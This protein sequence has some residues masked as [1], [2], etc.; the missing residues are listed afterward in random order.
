MKNQ[1]HS[2]KAIASLVL[3]AGLTFVNAAH[4]QTV[5][6]FNSDPFAGSTALVTPGRQV[7][8]GAPPAGKELFLPSFDTLTDLFAFDL[9]VPAFNSV[10]PL[11]FFKGFA[12][13]IPSTGFNVI[14]LQSID[15]DNNP[16]TGFNAG[17][18]ANLIAAELDDVVTPGFFVYRNSG[19]S[20]N[21]LVYSTDLSVNTA[22]LAVL[23]RITSPTGNFATAELAKFEAAN[24]ASV[25][26]PSTM[27]L[28]ALG[29]L[30][31]AAKRRSSRASF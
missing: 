19:L 14:V 9:T 3:L 25:P 6:K 18:A 12:S 15:N 1:T 17:T 7:F 20:L 4:A 31:I 22:D 11:S 10:G 27:A 30:A 16:A 23:A 8:Q 13:D 28:S 29:V 24:F 2:I 5:T 26:E 21:R